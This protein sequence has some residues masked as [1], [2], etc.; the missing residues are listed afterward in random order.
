V[1]KA[2]QY[3]I[4]CDHLHC[5]RFLYPPYHFKFDAKRNWRDMGGIIMPDGKTYCNAHW[6]TGYCPVGKAHKFVNGWCMNCGRA[7]E[8]ELDHMS[9][10]KDGLCDEDS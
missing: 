9:A 3:T 8:T 6:P 5:N 10:Q 7:K 1:I 4:F 2:T